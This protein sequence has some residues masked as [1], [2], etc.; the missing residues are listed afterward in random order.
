MINL[1]KNL[2]IL[3]YVGDFV[4]FGVYLALALWADLPAVPCMIGYGI[5][6]LAWRYLLQRMAYQR[7]SRITS[8]LENCRIRQ[9][10]SQLQ[11]LLSRCGQG[12][13]F[14]INADLAFGYLMLGEAERGLAILNALPP[15]PDKRGWL[16]LKL[17]CEGNRGAAY[18]MMN[19]LDEVEASIERYAAIL[20]ETP[21]KYLKKSKLEDSYQA[22]LIELQM[23]RGNFEGAVDFFRSRLQKAAT[24]RQEIY[25]HYMLAWALHH[26]G[27]TDE[28]KTHLQFVAENG[29]DTWFADSA[30]KKLET[31]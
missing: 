18:L 25:S 13:F 24:L 16:P 6:L 11:A 3:L 7:F 1:F 12:T 20:S 22:Q 15:F 30:Q 23:A 31:L 17:V 8:D 2:K 5:M 14:L 26:D 10:I 29:G 4:L 19:R 27:Y 9:G 21:K 28:A